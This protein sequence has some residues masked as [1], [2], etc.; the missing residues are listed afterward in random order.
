MVVRSVL[1][2]SIKVLDE[3]VNYINLTLIKKYFKKEHGITLKTSLV[4]KKQNVV[5]YI[6]DGT[7]WDRHRTQHN[8]QNAD[9]FGTRN[10]HK[11]HFLF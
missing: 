1:E 6:L 8:L 9:Q 5:Q 11:P 3:N 10:S 7:S 4:L 2:Q